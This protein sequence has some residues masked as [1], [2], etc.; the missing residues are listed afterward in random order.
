M[1]MRIR[2]VTDPSQWNAALLQLPAPHVLQTWEWGA[3]KGKYGWAP[4]HLLFEE[5]G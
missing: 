2:H 4:T 5:D 3:F 1:T